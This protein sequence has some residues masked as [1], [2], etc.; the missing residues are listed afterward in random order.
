[1][2][3]KFLAGAFIMALVATA[4]DR[5][6]SEDLTE[7]S[8]GTTKASASAE[9]TTTELG[10]TKG[11][12]EGELPAGPSALDNMADPSFPAPLIEPAEIISGGPP[13]DGIPSIDDPRFVP[14]EA[15]DQWLAAAEP[16]V[17]LEANGEVHAYPVQILI[18]HEIV[19]DTV[20]GIPVTVT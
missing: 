1:M 3:M 14:V 10:P 13:P 8:A 20:G 19:N 16:V 11:L 18:W 15:A 6:A 4:C 5:G 7:S 12:G 2:R 9:T 17:Y